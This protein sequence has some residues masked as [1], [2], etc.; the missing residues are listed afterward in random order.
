MCYAAELNWTDGT[1]TAFNNF[2]QENE[3]LKI[4][5]PFQDLR[6]KITGINPK[7]IR[8][9]VD[10]SRINKIENKDTMEKWVILKV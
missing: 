6:K 8:L 2:I 7:K 4:K 1:F 5:Y 9:R 10:K 3:W